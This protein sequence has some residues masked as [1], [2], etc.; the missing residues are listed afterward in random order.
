MERSSG[1]RCPGPADCTTF[2]PFT[3]SRGCSDALS[4]GNA[5]DRLFGFAQDMLVRVG[6]RQP[7]IRSRMAPGDAA[8]QLRNVRIELRP[9]LGIAEV[10]GGRTFDFAQDMASR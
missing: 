10:E 4:F 3:R 9:L 2:S 7:L 1:R 6:H 5:L 8:V